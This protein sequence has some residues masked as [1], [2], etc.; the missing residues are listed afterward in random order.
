MASIDSAII[1]IMGIKD[2]YCSTNYGHLLLYK[3]LQTT[4]IDNKGLYFVYKFGDYHYEN[5][6]D[7]YTD[8]PEQQFIDMNFKPKSNPDLN[9]FILPRSRH[10]YGN[11]HNFY[12][13]CHGS[14]V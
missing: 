13:S 2:G 10:L 5:D 14:K 4:N 1:H 3:V 9:E 11:A 12:G 7:S 8:W 6:Y